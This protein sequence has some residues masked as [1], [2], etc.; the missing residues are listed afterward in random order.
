MGSGWLSLPCNAPKAMRPANLRQRYPGPPCARHPSVALR[1]LR[2]LRQT[3]AM[4]PPPRPAIASAPSA[5]SEGSASPFV[6][7]VVPALNEERRIVD[8]LDA[9]QRQTYPRELVEI[10]VVDGRSADRTPDLVREASTRDSRVRLLDNPSG[11][12]AT[13]LNV[14]IEAAKGSV[15]CRMDGHA[16]AADD[17]VERGI[18]VLQATRAWCVGGQMQ[19]VGVTSVGKAIALASTSR[20]GV[21]DSAFHYA[22]GPR[23]VESVFLGCWP[24]EVFEKIGLFDPEL[25]RNQDDEL[26]YRIRKGGGSIRFD[27]SIRVRY[28]T[29][30]SLRGVFS[31]HRQ[32]GRWKI[33]VFQKHPGAVRWRHLVPGALVAALGSGLL[34][35]IY[36]PFGYLVLGAGATYSVAVAVVVERLRSKHGDVRRAYLAGAFAAMHLGYGLGLWQGLLVAAGQGLTTALSRGRA[37]PSESDAAP[38]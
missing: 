15:I 29:R 24:R 5:T 2:A 28:F 14:G 7:I 20:F 8:C 23:E 33:R 3:E 6:S 18:A 16:I 13:A 12:T 11:R 21:G 22:T 38:R 1:R 25:V 36:A 31:Q 10:L 26:S 34:A 19:K 37:R 35:P 32:Y 27:P 9:L 4:S 17:Y 30:D